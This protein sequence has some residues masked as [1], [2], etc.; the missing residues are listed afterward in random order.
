MLT[1]NHLRSNLKKTIW[2][3]INVLPIIFGM[4]LLTSLLMTLFPKLLSAG[5]FGKG[6]MLDS[7]LAAAIGSIAIGHPLASY[8]FAGEMLSTGVGLIP[9]TALIVAWVTVGAIQI[10]A[11]ALLL[12]MRFA[13]CRN[14]VAF[15][16]AIAISFLTAATLHWLGID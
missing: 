8:L 1:V 6:D 5:L 16:A 3:F 12:G 11:E 14:G 15:I 4:L 9:V 10:P 7:L 2:S 13:I